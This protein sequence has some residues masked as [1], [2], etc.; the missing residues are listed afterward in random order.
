MGIV[1]AVMARTAMA[2][3]SGRAILA[4]SPHPKPDAELEPK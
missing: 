3:A 1:N 2:G 4:P